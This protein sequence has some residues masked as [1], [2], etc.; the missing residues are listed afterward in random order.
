MFKNY[1]FLLP[2][3]WVDFWRKGN[4]CLTRKGDCGYEMAT[5]AYRKSDDG[6]NNCSVVGLNTCLGFSLQNTLISLLNFL[7]G[8]R[9]IFSHIQG[10]FTTVTGALPI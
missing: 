10:K 3:K 6:L 9:G 7:S 5:A 2:N 1:D 4:N 8:F